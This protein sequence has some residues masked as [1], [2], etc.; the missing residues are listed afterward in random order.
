MA[1]FKWQKFKSS[2]GL[3]LDW[4][5]ECDALTPADWKCLANIVRN[6]T[7]FSPYHKVISIP[8]GGDKLTKLLKPYEDPKSKRILICDDVLTSGK[9]MTEALKQAD[10][11][12][13]YKDGYDVVGLAVFNRSGHLHPYV[14]SLF[15]MGRTGY[16]KPIE[17]RR[18]HCFLCKKEFFLIAGTPLVFRM[19]TV[20]YRKTIYAFNEFAHVG[21]FTE[22]GK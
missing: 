5:I 2:A 22:K 21:C 13:P 6:D 11:L 17:K 19:T 14:E 4:K 9:S 3:D 12:F 16:P 20:K 7:R 18:R 15:N 8:R 10:K 1:L